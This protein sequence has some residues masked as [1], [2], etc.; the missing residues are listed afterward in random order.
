MQNTP[1]TTTLLHALL[2]NQ[3]AMTDALSK[4]ADWAEEGENGNG[5]A[6]AKSIR[7]SV[8][9]VDD[10]QRLLGQCISELMSR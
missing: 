2:K 9:C 6:V 1:A 8:K 4:L 3:R 7:E 5:A 10:S